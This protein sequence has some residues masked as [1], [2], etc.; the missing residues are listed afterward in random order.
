MNRLMKLIKY[1]FR[2]KVNKNVSVE[3][4]MTSDR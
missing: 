3:Q 4:K 1:F 2:K